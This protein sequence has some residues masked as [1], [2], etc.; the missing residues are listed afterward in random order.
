MGKVYK[1][2]IYP[3]PKMKVGLKLGSEQEFRDIERYLDKATFIEIVG[4]RGVDF[5]FLKGCGLPVVIHN[6]HY[7]CKGINFSNPTRQS[8]NKESL[9]Y[10]LRTA[11]EL[12]SE[13]IIVHPGLKEN[14]SCSV[15]Q[16][17][18]VLALYPDKRILIESMP[19]R[20]A[21]Y[22]VFGY[23]Y[24][25]LKRL[26]GGNK[27]FCL[28]IAHSSMAAFS[29]GKDPVDYI[30]KLLDLKPELYHFSDSQL[31]HQVDE[32]L[33][34]GDG[35]LP[36]TEVRGMLP[37]TAW[38]TLETPKNEKLKRDIEFLVN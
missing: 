25:T 10:S 34:L 35:N 1:K 26:I 2:I 16:T 31:E 6:E 22:D 29:L 30:K 3:Y 27:R 4:K 19:S 21:G 37:E 20:G 24:E 9:E 14:E 11:D 8:E 33:N 7:R 12:G 36:L 5:S 28:D 32:H 13:H 38:A 18:K 15:E 23:D 17:E